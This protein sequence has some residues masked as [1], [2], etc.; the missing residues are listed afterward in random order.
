MK[1][2]LIFTIISLLFSGC[3][4]FN[5]RGVSTQLYNDCKEYYD[6]AGMYHK[7]CDKNLVDYKDLNPKKLIK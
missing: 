2:A 7:E 3:V 1:K 4:Y 5:D 6:A